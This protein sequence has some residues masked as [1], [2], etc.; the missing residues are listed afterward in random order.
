[1]INVSTDMEA[2]DAKE[3]QIIYKNFKM[4]QAYLKKKQIAC[5]LKMLGGDKISMKSEES[6]EYSIGECLEEWE[7]WLHGYKQRKGRR[8]A[9][10]GE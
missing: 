9:E 4:R 10:K 2:L 3:L 7:G 1:M 8:L 6:G 5:K